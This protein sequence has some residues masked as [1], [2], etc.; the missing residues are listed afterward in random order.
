MVRV[1]AR[2]Y[3]RHRTRY[4][5]YVPHGRFCWSSW[6]MPNR[7]HRFRQDQYRQ[8]I[9]YQRKNEITH[10]RFPE[11]LHHHDH[12]FL[13]CTAF[14]LCKVTALIIKNLMDRLL[15]MIDTYFKNQADYFRWQIRSSVGRNST[16][17]IS[18]I[19]IWS[20]PTPMKIW[21]ELIKFYCVQRILFCRHKIPSYQILLN[22]LAA[23]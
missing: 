17:L 20:R 5:F 1:R 4:F 15:S 3:R 19:I 22:S 21:I 12:E 8:S 7:C 6:R 14:R 11:L 10:L 16:S 18:W 9:C 2:E 13:L 23:Y